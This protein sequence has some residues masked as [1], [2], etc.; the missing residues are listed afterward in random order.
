MSSTSSSSVPLWRDVRVYRIGGQVVF[1]LVILLLGW[2]FQQNMS[3]GLARI[4]NTLSFDFLRSAASIPLAESVI[5]YTPEDSYGYAFLVS[6][7]NTLRVAVVGIVLASALGLLIG[8]ARLSPNWL[9]AR[10]AQVY[11][12]IFRNTPLL[13]QLLFWY[14]AVIL[15]LPRVRESIQLPGSIFLN[16]RGLTVPWFTPNTSFATWLQLSG[17]GLLAA[18][19]IYVVLGLWK[20]PLSLPRGFWAVLAFLLTAAAGALTYDPF[21]PSVPRLEGFNFSGGLSL[22][23]EYVALLLA[24]VIYTSAF[25]SEIVRAGIQ[26][27]P[28]GL[29]E[30][31]RALGLGYVQT[32]RLVTV[33]IALRVIIPPLTNQYLNLTKN[34]SLA[35]A[36]GYADLFYVSQTIFN[37]TGQTVQIVVMIMTT[38][39]TLSLSIALIM[40]V[41][42]ARF[43]LVER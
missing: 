41:V 32:L 26:A 36:I 5:P 28:R 30:A 22:S 17:A 18:L 1:V 14:L 43:K 3:R 29:T 33:P 40:N 25:I 11:V 19:I 10:S 34:S 20:R 6:V 27:V 38:Y 4:G 9:I 15:K 2:W 35:A 16:N 42:N 7:L 39:L 31:A 13:L 8:V 24:L 23:P 12:E 21:I 37:G